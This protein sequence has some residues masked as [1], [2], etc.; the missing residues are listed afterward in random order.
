M[1]T[2]TDQLIADALL[3]SRG[4]LGDAARHLSERLGRPFSRTMLAE[5][6]QTSRVFL[7][8]QQIA[9][10]RAFARAIEAG[11]E[12]RRQ[13]RSA[14]M[15]AA[16]ARRKEQTDAAEDLELLDVLD[17]PNARVRARTTRAITPAVVQAARDQRLCMAKT[18]KGTP[19]IRRVIPGKDRCPSHGGKSTGPRTAEG[20][21][22]IAA[23]QHARWERFRQERRA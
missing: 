14:A 21:A 7:A 2:L 20:K 18:R 11:R 8:V 9:E 17:V 10:Q 5:L 15:K 19:C 4:Y 13:R 16:W 23:A 12:V 22:R 1:P 3:A 6:V